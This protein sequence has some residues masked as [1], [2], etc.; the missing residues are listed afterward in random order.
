VVLLKIN[1]GCV[2][3]VPAEGDTPRTIDVDAVAL[4]F[5]MQRMEVEP[6]NVHILRTLNLLEQVETAKSP[7]LEIG[8]DCFRFPFAEEFRQPFALEGLD[9][10]GIL[11]N[12]Q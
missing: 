1:S 5:P 12:Q 6:W 9:H 3:T 7:F 2:L 8:G 10:V 4:W 11:V